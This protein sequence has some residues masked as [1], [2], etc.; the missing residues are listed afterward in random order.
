[1]GKTVGKF[2]YIIHKM[3]P[4]DPLH[5][6]AVHIRLELW[7]EI[8]GDI[9]LLSPNLWSEAEIDERIELLKDELD[10]VGRRAKA[11]IRRAQET[12]QEIIQS[13]NSN[14]RYRG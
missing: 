7:S 1:M 3:K 9:P 2:G 10:S 11:A 6:P 4:G 14:V 12:T 8:E 13:R 5:P